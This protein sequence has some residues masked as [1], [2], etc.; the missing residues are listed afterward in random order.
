MLPDYLWKVVV[1]L[2]KKKGRN[3]SQRLNKRQ[4]LR[5][6]LCETL[7]EWRFQDPGIPG[8]R[9][10]VNPA[11]DDILVDR[12]MCKCAWVSIQRC[13]VEGV[14]YIVSTKPIIW[15]HRYTF[16]LNLRLHLVESSP[17]KK[18]IVCFYLYAA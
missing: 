2:S 15:L 17:A 9:A 1:P 5:Q 11:H 8:S 18:L 16:S 12:T 10:G 6:L 3:V 13:P 7:A 14:V 4:R